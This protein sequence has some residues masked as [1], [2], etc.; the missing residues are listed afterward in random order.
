M[1]K[2]NFPGLF[3]AL[4]GLDGSG[5]SSQVERLKKNL[6]G[7][8]FKAHETKEP[9]NN[10]I[11]GLIRGVLTK[12]WQIEPEG[13]QLL[14]A[15]DRSHHL[16]HII[17]PQLEKGRIIISD[18]YAFSSI[19]YGS[20]ELNRAWLETINEKFILPDIT[21]LLKVAP[22]VCIERID[23][24][25][26]HLEL[27][28]DKKKLLKVWQTYEKLAENQKNSI[29]VVDG[30]RTKDEVEAEVIKIIKSGLEKKTGLARQG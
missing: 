18:R 20:L 10:M 25:R 8:G 15:A 14:F 4:E 19:A 27:F 1:I 5:S 6:C 30:E 9:T 28:E 29:V 21:I 11:G 24:S 13:F 16:R 17:I 3:I 12:Q 26:T 2:H 22:R 7:L 23:N